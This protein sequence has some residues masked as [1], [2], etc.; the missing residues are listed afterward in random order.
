MKNLPVTYVAVLQRLF[1]VLL[2]AF[3]SQLSLFAQGTIDDYRRAYSAQRTFSWSKVK[4]HVD[5]ARWLSNGRFQYHV[6][7]GARGTWH[8]GQV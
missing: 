4:N 1:S 8:F 3:L 7:D 6:T 5:D 2:V